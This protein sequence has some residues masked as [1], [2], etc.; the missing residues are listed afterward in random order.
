M[1]K[2]MLDGQKLT[3]MAVINAMRDQMRVNDRGIQEEAVMNAMSS[4]KRTHEQ[5]YY[6]NQPNQP[7]PAPTT[8]TYP[9]PVLPPG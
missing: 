9:M 6:S 3:S 8:L 2:D 5:A 7:V 4:G 1:S